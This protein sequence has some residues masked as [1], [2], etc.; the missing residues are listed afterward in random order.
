[1]TDSY[2]Q[3][4]RFS[5]QQVNEFARLSGDDN[6]LH[7]DAA[8]AATTVFKRPVVHGIFATSIFSKVL[9]TQFP[10]YGSIYLRQQVEFLRPIYVDTDYVA[11]FRVLET[12]PEKHTAEILTEI[13]DATTQKACVR[14][15]ATVMHPTHF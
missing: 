14:G 11:R 10:G 12:N 9:G 15:Q 6:P 4:F 13:I 3:A 2:Q 7:L 8:F 1:M 5:Q